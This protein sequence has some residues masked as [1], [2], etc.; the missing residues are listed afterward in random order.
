[1]DLLNKLIHIRCFARSSEEMFEDALIIF[2]T[3]YKYFS[4]LQK[5]TT[6]QLYSCR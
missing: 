1:M 3:L 2:A 4:T 5:F 6:F